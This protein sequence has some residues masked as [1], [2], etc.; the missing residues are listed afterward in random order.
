MGKSTRAHQVTGELRVPVRYASA[1]APT[2][3]GADWIGRQWEA[4]RLEAASQSGAVLVLDELQKIPNWSEAVKR[5]WGED[6]RKRLPLKGVLPGSPPLLIAQGLTESLAGRFETLPLPRWSYTEMRSALGWSLEQYLYCGRYPG[7]APLAG[8]PAPLLRGRL[9]ESA[10]GAH[11]AHAAAIG[12][13]ARHDRRERGEEVDCVVKSRSAPTAIEVM[14][15]RA[16]SVHPGSAAFK[17]RRAVLVGGDGIPVE[18]FLE[19]PVP[20]WLAS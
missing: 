9:I 3:R 1:D 4:A 15:G 13:C 10:S 11:L 16:P 8:D 6:T 14:S 2:L 20:R 12:E 7:A 19:R 18:D 5:L 17:V